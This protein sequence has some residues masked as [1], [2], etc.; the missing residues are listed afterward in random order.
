[1]AGS[2]IGTIADT[3]LNPDFNLAAAVRTLA[4]YL[5]IAHHIP[6]R[7]RFK[8]D[9]AVLQEPA[10]QGLGDEG[11]SAALG[12]IR[13][14]RDIRLNKLARSCTIEYDTGIIPAPAW[15]DLLA[16]QESPAAAALFRIIEE[17][18]TEV[19]HGQL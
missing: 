5:R 11:L 6:G 3:A 2:A 1:M 18:Y 4:P 15:S 16:G 19:R 17:K 9:T 10:L 12:A 7:I 8:I 14:V 13:G